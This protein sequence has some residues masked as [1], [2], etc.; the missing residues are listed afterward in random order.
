[1]T[2]VEPLSC[3][4]ASVRQLVS[5]QQGRATTTNNTN[6]TTLGLASTLGSP[7]AAPPSALTVCSPVK[8]RSPAATKLALMAVLPRFISHM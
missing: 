6:V 2:V 7:V 3:L 1:M 5:L 4:M 8:A